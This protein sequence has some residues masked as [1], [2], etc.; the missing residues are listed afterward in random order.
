[1]HTHQ[2]IYIYMCVCTYIPYLKSKLKL[3]MA[4]G[5]LGSIFR[6]GGLFTG[7]SDRDV[8]TCALGIEGAVPGHVN[9]FPLRLRSPPKRTHKRPNKKQKST[10]AVIDSLIHENMNICPVHPLYEPRKTKHVLT[11]QHTGRIFWL[12]L[13][14]GVLGFVSGEMHHGSSASHWGCPIFLWPEFGPWADLRAQ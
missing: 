13:A 1:M 2:Y 3:R 5:L 9:S 4:S 7:H 14:S 6:L 10:R 12:I 11:Q 8:R